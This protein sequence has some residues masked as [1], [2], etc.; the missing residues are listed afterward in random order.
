L[1]TLQIVNAYASPQLIDDIRLLFDSRTFDQYLDARLRLSQRTSATIR[2]FPETIRSYIRRHKS[3][4]HQMVIHGD[5]YAHVLHFGSGEILYEF[6]AE[7]YQPPGI[8][9]HFVIR[10]TLYNPMDG[11]A[12]IGDVSF[13]FSTERIVSNLDAADFTVAALRDGAGNLYDLKGGDAAPRTQ[14]DPGALIQ[15]SSRFSYELMTYVDNQTLIQTNASAITTLL[16]VMLALGTVSAL[17]FLYSIR[18]D[19]VFLQ[20]IFA[21]IDAVKQ[22]HFD[23]V[24]NPLR[25]R[26]ERNE[27]GRISRELD[28]MSQKLKRTIQSEYQLKIQQQQAEMRMLQ[29]QINPHFLNNTLEAISAQALLNHDKPTSDAISALGSLFRDM[30][31]LPSQI[32]LR[33][34]VRILQTYLRVMAFKCAGTFFYQ[35][36]LAPELLE[37]QTVKFWMQPLAENFFSHG[38]DPSNPY[39]LLTVQAYT[40]GGAV[41]ID[42]FNNGRAIPQ[43]QLR[44]INEGLML[45]EGGATSIGLRNVYSRLSLFYPEGL[46]LAVANASAN[47]EESGVMIR[48]RIQR[49]E[50]DV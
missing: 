3:A 32:P 7:A 17:F 13:L 9:D 8:Q 22:G 34:E 12:E 1:L 40:E 24:G 35:V 23:T 15:Q 21:T 45:P 26:Y 49:S 19:A 44:A 14:P 25:T 16:I 41:C 29:S 6:A 36:N 18:Y 39:N 10:K 48:I 43:E 27:Y 20:D 38:F 11:F 33:D 5:G 4:L 28:D 47:H 46:T 37:F 31:H 42:M 30:L 2:S 50:P